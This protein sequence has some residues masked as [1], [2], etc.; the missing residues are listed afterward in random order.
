MVRMGE[1]GGARG[2]V[3]LLVGVRSG[4]DGGELKVRHAVDVAV[5]LRHEAVGQGGVDPV[6]Y[7]HLTLPTN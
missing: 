1:G 6:S 2:L 7:T 5:A 4:G 3:L